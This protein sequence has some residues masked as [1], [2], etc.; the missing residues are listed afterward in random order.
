MFPVVISQLAEMGRARTYTCI[1]LSLPP[2]TPHATIL[3]AD[4]R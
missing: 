2:K 4:Y 1:R 3:G